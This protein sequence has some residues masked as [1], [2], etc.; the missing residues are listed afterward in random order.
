MQ[1]SPN[2]RGTTCLL[3]DV[4]RGTEGTSACSV[5]EVEALKVGFSQACGGE[6]AFRSSLLIKAFL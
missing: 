1:L 4:P 5:D 2:P 3:P 6:G